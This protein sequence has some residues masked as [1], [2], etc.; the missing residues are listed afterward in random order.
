M[1]REETKLMFSKEILPNI[2]DKSIES[3]F[4]HILFNDKNN[5]DWNDTL[6]VV[7]KYMPELKSYIKGEPKNEN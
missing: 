4:R 2:K 7:C 6:D 3:V 5:I 1:T